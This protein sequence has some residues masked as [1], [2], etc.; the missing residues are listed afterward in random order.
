MRKSEYELLMEQQLIEMNIPY[1]AEFRFYKKRRWRSD[2]AIP[3]LRILIEVEGGIW[4]G[5]RHTRGA[6]FTNDCE[7][8]NT[9]S[10]M[11]YIV[12]RFTPEQI[13]SSYARRTIRKAIDIGINRMMIDRKN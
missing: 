10:L 2:F 3:D 11:G 5:G 1:V 7:K 9:A 6:G 13:E 4:S 12:L 8:Y